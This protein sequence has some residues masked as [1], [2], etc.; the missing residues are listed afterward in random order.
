M[1]GFPVVTPAI[2]VDTAPEDPARTLH[3]EVCKALTRH[4]MFQR[5]IPQTYI[6]SEEKTLNRT[7]KARHQ[8][9]HDLA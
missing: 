2:S 9:H 7:K 8:H 1:S 3:S 5:F 6:S 4:A